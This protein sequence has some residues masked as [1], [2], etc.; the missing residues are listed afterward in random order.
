MTSPL[1]VNR[2]S[3]LDAAAR[4][5]ARAPALLSREDARRLTAVWTPPDPEFRQELIGVALVA[6]ICKPGAQLLREVRHVPYGVSV[7]V[8]LEALRD[9]LGKL[10]HLAGLLEEAEARAAVA[11]ATVRQERAGEPI[12]ATRRHAC[13]S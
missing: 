6:L 8:L 9:Y 2:P 13:A 1:L 11:L 10:H 7:G 3:A 4:Q 5:L 12:T